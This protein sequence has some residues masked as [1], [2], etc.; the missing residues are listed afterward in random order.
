MTLP[1]HANPFNSAF[2]AGI[3]SV[4]ILVAAFPESL[5]LQRLVAF[6]YLSVHSGDAAGP[7]SLHPPVPLRTGEL[8]I[9][10]EL[11]ERGLLLMVSRNLVVRSFNRTGI[12]YVATDSARPF[13][14]GLAARYT[15]DLIDRA[16][17][18]IANFSKLSTPIMRERMASLLKQWTVE[19]EDRRS[20]GVLL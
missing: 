4:V 3:R 10:S 19:F 12:D 18:V 16:D 20:P 2:E 17:W 13:L 9:R 1:E 8:L 7:S 14:D 6:D 5:D 11:I 15:R